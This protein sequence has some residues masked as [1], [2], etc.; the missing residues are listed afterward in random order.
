MSSCCVMRDICPFEFLQYLATDLL[1]NVIMTGVPNDKKGEVR[2]WMQTEWGKETFK[3]IG[4]RNNS[5]PGLNEL[6]GEIYATLAKHFGMPEIAGET[7]VFGSGAVAKFKCYFDSFSQIQVNVD[8]EVVE[9]INADY[10]GISRW[11]LD[12]RKSFKVLPLC[13]YN[14]MFDLD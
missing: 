2:D 11:V 13:D 14:L 4:G 6:S 7:F 3:T 8:P 9:K 10:R 1:G 5:F 12:C